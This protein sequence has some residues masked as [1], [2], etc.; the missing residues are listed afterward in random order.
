ME[1]Q[2]G[3][4]L[5]LLADTVSGA[6]TAQI[7]GPRSSR[8]IEPGD[9]VLSDIVPRYKGYWGDTCNTCAVGEPSEEQRRMF[10]GI[11]E[12]LASTIETVR[13]AFE[14]VISIASCAGRSSAWEV[15]FLTTVATTSA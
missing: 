9:L 3:V 13:P 7:G 6:R 2:A 10:K 11:A 12:A 4:R 1:A 14:P 5:P 15:P 8:R